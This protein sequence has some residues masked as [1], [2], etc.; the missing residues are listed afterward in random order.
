MS[1]RLKK[2]CLL[3]LF[4]LFLLAV[5]A[6]G[7][8]NSSDAINDATETSNDESEA[9]EPVT[10]SFLVD[11]QTVMDGI[12]AVAENIE[13][14][15]NI[16]TEFEIRPGGTE[17]DNVVK[18]RLATGDM[19]DMMWYNSG[20]L[21]KALNPEQY[22]LDLSDQEFIDRL[23]E[24]FVETVSV[25]GAVYG[26]PGESS[27]AGGM[28][29]NKRVYEELGLDVPQTW[30]DFLDNNEAVKQADL[31]PVIAS[32]Q[33]SWTSQVILLGD[34]YNVHSADPDFADRFTNNESKFAETPIAIRGFEKIQELHDLDLYN[35]ERSST[36]YEDALRML[37]NG[38]AAHYPMLSFALQAIASTY[39][40][41]D[42]IGFFPIP[43][44][45]PED[46]GLTQWM[47]GSIYANKDSQHIDAIIKWMEY[48][49]SDE[50]LETYMSVMQATG[51]YVLEDVQLPDDAF[52]AVQDMMEYTEAGKVAPALEF[53][54]PLKG[55]NLEQITVEV[56]LGMTPATEAAANYDRDVE[57]QAKQLG[58]EGW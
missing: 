52:E 27:S 34:Y 24:A 12:E 29:Y 4:A 23:Q 30:N 9:H 18:T 49:V 17:G 35:G 41:A 16:T 13:N 37:S 58:I 39:P 28:L 42:E 2:A 14:L 8:D 36:T 3:S 57:R 15:Y 7:D 44:D 47:P 53:L 22:F 56:G 32:Y 55:P 51:P 21:F 20:S 43:G 31:V 33:D 25:D 40:D 48:F 10:L 54:S 38:E 46:F 11:N 6:C 50:G 5:A 45:D 26:I 1:S 19:A